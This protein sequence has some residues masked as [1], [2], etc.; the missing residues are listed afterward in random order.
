MRPDR[1]AFW[2]AAEAEYP[3]ACAGDLVEASA[4]HIAPHAHASDPV[5]ERAFC[6]TRGCAEDLWTAA[7]DPHGATSARP[8]GPQRQTLE[9]APLLRKPSV[10]FVRRVARVHTDE[11]PRHPR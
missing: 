4:P 11:R 8:Q 9:R 2:N 5:L 7:S 10:F 3:V 1:D 6:R